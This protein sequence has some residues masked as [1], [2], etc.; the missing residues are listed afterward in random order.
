MTKKT[1]DE[2]SVKK[3]IIMAGIVTPAYLVGKS[4]FYQAM[5]SKGLGRVVGVLGAGAMTALTGW[6]AYYAMPTIVERGFAT[7]HDHV[8]INVSKEESDAD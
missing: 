8:K 6:S 2:E 5:Q 3:A 7:L 1:L 4:Y